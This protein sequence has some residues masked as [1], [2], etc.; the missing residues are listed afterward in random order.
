MLLALEDTPGHRHGV[1]ALQIVSIR[2]ESTTKLLSRYHESSRS[3]N[4]SG[5][6]TEIDC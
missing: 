3:G 2:S 1:P 4:G 6:K 5:I